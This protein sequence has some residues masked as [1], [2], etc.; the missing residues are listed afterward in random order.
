M[1][2]YSSMRLVIIHLVPFLVGYVSVTLGLRRR[3]THETAQ[4]GRIFIISI[5]DTTVIHS[6]ANEKCSV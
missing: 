2:Q 6:M 4:R 5:D 1:L 3:H